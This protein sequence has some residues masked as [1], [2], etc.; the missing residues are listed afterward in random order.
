MPK[1]RGRLF[2]KS[3]KKKRWP[4]EESNANEVG[5]AKDGIE[6]KEKKNESRANDNA[7][8]HPAAVRCMMVVR[9]GGVD[10][11]CRD[12]PAKQCKWGVFPLLHLRCDNQI[13]FSLNQLSLVLFVCVP[14]L[15]SWLSIYTPRHSPFSKAGLSGSKGGPPGDIIAGIGT[16]H[17]LLPRM[18]IDKYVTRSLNI[19]CGALPKGPYQQTKR[20]V[21]PGGHR[22]GHLSADVSGFGLLSSTTF[23]TKLCV[24]YLRNF[25]F[26]RHFC[27]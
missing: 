23:C 8:Y 12:T 22:Q 14:D 24:C 25:F 26:S 10:P 2:R 3:P 16:R 19:C 15:V 27:A 18:S 1:Y 17:G 5:S 4:L 9:V 7:L 6:K 21:P 13:T 11:L 20:I